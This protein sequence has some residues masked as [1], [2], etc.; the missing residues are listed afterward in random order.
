MTEGEATPNIYR[1]ASRGHAIGWFTT[2]HPLF[3]PVDPALEVGACLPQVSDRIRSVPNDGVGYGIL[4]HLSPPSSE[5]TRLRALPEPTVLVTHLAT[6]TSSFDRGL[7]HLRNRID[8]Q[9]R[10]KRPQTVGFGIVI[11]SWTHQGTL[12]IA[13]AHD[14]SLAVAEMTALADHLAAAL[15]EPA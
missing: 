7:R 1:A 11:S 2:L 14:T 9:L 3:L 6:D 8:L 13:V 15:A 10:L 4:R 5:V 12:T